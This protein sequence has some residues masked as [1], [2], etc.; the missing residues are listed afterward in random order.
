VLALS[1]SLSL[2][3][4]VY[5]AVFGTGVSYL[6]KLVTAGPYAHAA[7]D[8]DHLNKKPSRPLSAAPDYIDPSILSNDEG[9]DS[10][11]H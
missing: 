3:I 11:G 10:N 4:V 6:L 7:A 9:R 8:V 1:A 5:V 2:F